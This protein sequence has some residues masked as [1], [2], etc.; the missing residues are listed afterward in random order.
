MKRNTDMFFGAKYFWCIALTAIIMCLL[1]CSRIITGTITDRKKDIVTIDSM[2][3]F[4]VYDTTGLHIGKQVSFYPT[5]NRSKIN[6]KRKY[7][8]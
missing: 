1:S 4:K 5:V 8:K 2:Y 6:S 3:K 7:Q